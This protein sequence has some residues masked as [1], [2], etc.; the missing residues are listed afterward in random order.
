MKI[1]QLKPL[2]NAVTLSLK[3][4]SKVILDPFVFSRFKNL[5]AVEFVNS[6][7][8]LLMWQSFDNVG[9]DVHA[10][11]SGL[12]VV[13]NCK[14]RW[15]LNE[16]ANGSRTAF[17][18]AKITRTRSLSNRTLTQSVEADKI[19]A[20]S[21]VVS[22]SN[23]ALIS[24]PCTANGELESLPQDSDLFEWLYEDRNRSEVRWSPYVGGFGVGLGTAP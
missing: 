7:S 13:C 14:N 20:D 3:N 1:A 19:K 12:E 9:K 24:F 4:R 17:H 6:K 16:T 2:E 22:G 5:T 15:L 11:L 18:L 10:N 8:S 23:E 21:K